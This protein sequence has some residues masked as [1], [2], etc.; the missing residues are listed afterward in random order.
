MKN[1]IIDLIESYNELKEETLD[2]EDRK[3]LSKKT[4]GLPEERKFPLNDEGHVKS[5]IAYFYNCPDNKKPKLAKAIL[6]AA[7]KYNMNID[8]DT[9]VYKYAQK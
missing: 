3:Q 9:T 7:K 5:A 2:S 4:F 6:K 8:K 1:T